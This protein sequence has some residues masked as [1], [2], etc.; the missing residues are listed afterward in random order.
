MDFIKEWITNIILFVLLA[1]VIDML[2]PNSNLQ[3]YIK[4]VTGLLLIAIILTPILKL[5]S[6]DF[7]EVLAAI[8]SIEASGE[9]N[10][11]NSI[12]M[13]KKEIQAFQHAY[14]LE[15]MR[16][17]LKKDTEEELMEQYGLEIVN[18]DFLADEYDQRASPENLQK[19]VVYL[20]HMDEV[21]E[22]VEVVKRVE[23]NTEETLPSNQANDET[24]KVASLIA[25]KLG[26]DENMIE[27]S[28]EGGK[29]NKDG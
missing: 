17:Q 1:T 2:L 6:N 15:E 20:K 21:T 25:Q 22:A 10:L 18:V 3:K 26:V 23:I 9:K 5:V 11:E 19:V 27:V 12:E 29:M 16:V 4:M 8:P 14:I 24:K 13:Q 7:E 28:V